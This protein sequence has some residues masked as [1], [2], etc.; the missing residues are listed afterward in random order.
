MGRRP[1]DEE[2]AQAIE[3]AF[4]NVRFDWPRIRETQAARAAGEERAAHSRPDGRGGER[5]LLR[6]RGAGRSRRDMP[7]EVV[8][9]PGVKPD[10]SS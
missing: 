5:R 6:R 1:L 10:D 9:P 7:A 8:R 3:E 2:T 4:P